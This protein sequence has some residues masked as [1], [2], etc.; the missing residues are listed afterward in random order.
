[1]LKERV[2]AI[3]KAGANVILSTMGIDDL[4]QKFLVENN[5]IGVRRINKQELRRI[6]RSCGASIVTT[7]ANDDGT[8]GFDPN[9]I[10]QAKVVYEDTVGDMDYLFIEVQSLSFCL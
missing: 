5:M 9:C 7:M 3:I 2:D 4:A 10:G 1:M 6:A 8:E